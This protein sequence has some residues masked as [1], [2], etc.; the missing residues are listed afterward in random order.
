MPASQPSS[1]RAGLSRRRGSARSTGCRPSSWPRS[2]PRAAVPGVS[3]GGGISGPAARSS[4]NASSPRATPGGCRTATLWNLHGSHVIE[5]E[6][7]GVTLR[8]RVKGI[9][10]RHT[11]HHFRQA[12]PGI[13]SAAEGQ[14]DIGMV[15]VEPVKGHPSQAD[16]YLKQENP[17]L[18]VV[19]YDP[20]IAPQSVHDPA[21]FG[22]L[23]TLA[24][25]M[26]SMRVNRFTIG[27]TRWG[28][29]NDLLVFIAHLSGCPDARFVLIDL[30]GGRSARPVLKSG[31][32]EYVVT[33]VDDAR[34]YLR[35]MAAEGKARQMY[36]YDG[37]EQLLATEETP[38]LVH[39]DRR[40]V[41]AD[42]HRG[43][44][45]RPRV[46][47]P[48]R[49]HGQPDAVAS[50]GTCGS[51][52]RTDPW[53][54]RSAPSRSARTCR[55]GPAT[56]SLRPGTAR[57]ASPSTTSSTRAGSRKRGPATSSTARTRPPS[58]SAPR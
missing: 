27:M 32:A 53:R 49:R 9:Q 35:M 23:E 55:G 31:T 18:G 54:H 17:L 34:M 15:R 10:G 28:K 7:R 52:P 33:E 25:K 6:L 41:R 4:R 24:W 22:K 5:A 39:D 11:I 50:R 8:I 43:R 1:A 12:V 14:A 29:S 13:E 45:R 30:K 36:A 21:P 37:N 38:G 2:W 19:E 56:G 40:D 20:E 58:R 44:R 51:T 26:V 57:T 16:I 3:S 42:R 47:P 46:P 48:R